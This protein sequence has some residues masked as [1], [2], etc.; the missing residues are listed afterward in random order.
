MSSCLHA[1]QAP[2]PKPPASTNGVPEGQSRKLSRPRR[3]RSMR[4]GTAEIQT[5]WL[6]DPQYQRDTVESTQAS[7]DKD[8][9]F[10][11]NLV[12]VPGQHGKCSSIKLFVW[13]SK[14]SH[15]DVRWKRKDEDALK[16]SSRL[17]QIS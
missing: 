8:Y 6:P 14:S 4:R 3:R 1:A 15:K 10:L 11:C 9:N 16:S 13:R 7:L 5:T 12:K 2:P 17:Y